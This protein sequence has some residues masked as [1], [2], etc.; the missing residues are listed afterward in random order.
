[1]FSFTNTNPSSP[2][3]A[4]TVSI[5][6]LRAEL[7]SALS[8]GRKWNSKVVETEMMPLTQRTVLEPASLDAFSL[9]KLL[10]PSRS[11]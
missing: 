11:L 1:M 8:D 7:F 9:I 10:S 2:Q 5:A 6:A 4:G 3:D